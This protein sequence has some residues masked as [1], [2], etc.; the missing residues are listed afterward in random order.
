MNRLIISKSDTPPNLGSLTSQAQD[1]LAQNSQLRDGYCCAVCGQSIVR[2]EN[3]I[4]VEGAHVH[5]CTNPV[6]TTFTIRCFLHALGC[7][8]R[9]SLTE[10]HSWFDG[11]RW[12]S[13]HCRGCGVQLGWYFL[14]D[15]VSFYALIAPRIITC[16]AQ[17]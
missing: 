11:Y 13:A 1:Q 15:R 3:A 2:A 6:G 17:L 7:E 8:G 14:R 10:Y 9:G 12:N 4:E 5:R 16:R